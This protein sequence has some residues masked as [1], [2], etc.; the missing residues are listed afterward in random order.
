MFNISDVKRND[1]VYENEYGISDEYVAVTD[2]AR[3]DGG[4]S[5]LG[6]NT[7]TSEQV[8]FYVRDGFEG[9]CKL[10]SYPH[11]QLAQGDEED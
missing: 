5:F 11:Y 9:M 3:E 2:A 4:W 1:R 8:R 6:E 7:L 10:D